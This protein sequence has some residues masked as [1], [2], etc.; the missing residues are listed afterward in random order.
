MQVL[1]FASGFLRQRAGAWLLLTPILALGLSGCQ[2]GDA[3][4]SAR[5]QQLFK[6]CVPCHGQQ[7]QGRPDLGAPNIAG[8]SAWYVQAQLQNFRSG[9]RGMDFNDKEGMRMRPMA[10]SLPYDADVQAIAE[11]V[12]GLPP[13]THAP[14]PGGNAQAGQALFAVCSACHGPSG[15]GNEAVKA[16]RLAGVDGSYLA[17]QLEKYKSGIRGGNPQDTQG[18][19]MRSAVATLSDDKAIQ[20]VVAYVGTLK[21]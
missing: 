21:P 13:V 8:M 6:T 18:V 11:Y 3:S 9:L 5:S 15:A 20:D 14:L 16:P 1:E 7:G 17:L 19:L 10:L 2:L 12:A 4:A